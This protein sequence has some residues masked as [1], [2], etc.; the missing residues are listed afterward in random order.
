MNRPYQLGLWDMLDIVR[1]RRTFILRVLAVGMGLGALLSWVVHPAYRASAMITADKMPPVIL[2][3][4]PSLAGQTV[5]TPLLGVA[6]PDL[7]TLV[8]LVKSATVHDHA[9]AR[10]ASTPG[11]VKAAEALL[12]TLRVQP[13]GNTQLVRITIEGRDPV[14]AA[15]AVNA[16]TAS[17]VD[18]DLNG[19][20]QWAREMRQSIEQQLVLADPRL[21]AAE[22][23]IVAFKAQYGDVPMSEAAVAGLTRLAQLEAQRVDVRMQL[24]EARARIDAA[25]NRLSRQAQ[26]TPT[27]WK[28]SPLINT[29]QAQLATQE[30]ELSGLTRQFTAKHPSVVTT[31]AKIAETKQ[32]LDSEVNHTLLIDQY[33]VDPVYQQLAQQLRQDEL[34]SAALDVR[35]RA[36]TVA[37][38]QHEGAVRKLP[39][40]ELIQTRLLRNVKE[41][42]AI[43]QVLTGKLHQAFVAESTI[44]TVIRIV[45]PAK[46]PTSPVGHRNLGLL[47]GTIL[48][49]VLGVGGALAGEQIQNPVKSVE[50]GQQV[51]GIPVLG[52]IPQLNSGEEGAPDTPERGKRSLWGSVLPGRVS[53]ARVHASPA[54]S[55]SAF[56]ESFRYLRT[57]LLC[58][59][60]PPL[61]TLMV[62]SAGSGDGKDLVAANL[63][64]A[65]AHAG[66]R[67]WLVDCDLRAPAFDHAPIFG[68]IRPEEAAAGIAEVLGKGISARHLVRQTAVENLWFLPAG[69]TPHN[70]AELLGSRKM[71]AFLH[72]DRDDID[73]IVLAAPP[74]LAVADAAVLAPMVQGALLVVRIGTT[75]LE[76]AQRA[77]RQLEAV[78]AQVLGAV[79]TGTAMAGAG[80]YFHYYARRYGAG[81]SG[82]WYFGPARRQGAAGPRR[83]S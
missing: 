7:Y 58:L 63:A 79:A 30:I 39:M 28:P 44:G 35:D 36:L 43:H 1:R 53:R 11:E 81:P 33:G 29:L 20:R 57:N 62:T 4:Q 47:M 34:A 55:R 46:P 31:V 24:Q 75:T 40:R 76:A 69:T 74:V 2:L 48:G 67:V 70:S 60:K 80:D 10:L 45:D 32:K 14:S 13:S 78:G 51:L 72:E 64:I 5:G 21:R 9:L 23:S 59:R 83:V 16:V 17:L 38:E 52:A 54:L 26:V 66:L 25:R 68:G 6:S 73:V 3:D 50:H 19:R 42:E 82:E 27:Q 49:L 71:Q 77:R 37:I 61:R 41:A 65:F 56:A 12:R 22:D 18:L 15:E 8:A